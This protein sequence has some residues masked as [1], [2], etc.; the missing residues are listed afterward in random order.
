MKLIA[1][2]AE[3]KVFLDAGK[4][5]KQRFSKKYREKEL[6]EYLR[7]TRT[8]KEAKLLADVKRSGLKVPTVYEVKP[9]EIEIEY[10]KGIKLKEFLDKDNYG[11]T[12]KKL[13]ESI[14]KLHGANIIHGDLTTLNVIVK[15]DEFYFIDFGLGIETQSLEQKASDL[16][17]LNQNFKSIHPEFD[18]WKS[19]L[20]G[21]KNKETEKIVEVFE[22]MLKRRRYI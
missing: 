20:K 15:N 22:K 8:K 21:Y 3:A 13:G 16:L 7:K 14:S 19:F 12:C 1:Q 18:C 17:T 4:I 5:I 11:E 6:D 10:I 2:G 9:F